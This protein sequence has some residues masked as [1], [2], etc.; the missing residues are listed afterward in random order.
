MNMEELTPHI[1]ELKRVLGDKANEAMIIEELDTYLNK[2]H[3]DIESAKRGIIRK[4]GGVTVGFVTAAAVQKKI[5]DL[6]GTEQ[7]VDIVAKVI[8]VENKEITVKGNPK[9]IVSG[10]IGDDT[11]SSSFTIWR[12]DV[13]LTK[14]DV[15]RF[16]NCYTKKWNDRI[17]VNLGDKGVVEL[18]RDVK[19]DMPERNYTMSSSEMKIGEIREGVGNVTVTGRIM[20]AETKTVNVKG[21]PKTV[22]AGIIADDTGKIQY[23]AWN[24]FQLKAGETICVKNA[25]IRA[26]KGIPQL[27]LG[28]RCEVSRVD[29]TFDDSAIGGSKE[30]TVRDILKNGGGLDIVLKGDVVDIRM[31]SGL[32]KRCPECNRSI[33]NDQCVS[34]GTVNPVPDLR[35]KFILDDGTGSIS[36]VL[37]RELT[38]K[39]TGVT[40]SAATELGKARGAEFVAKDLAEKILVKHVMITGNVMSDDY[41]PM[42]VVRDAALEKVDVESEARA[43]YK[44]VEAAL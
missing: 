17:Q 28:E 13:Q 21:E 11:G 43:L 41:G 31:G 20:T 2:Y 44:T 35:L 7:N 34:H 16:K 10:I 27:N 33:L 32:I 23:S 42:M 40:L 38:K 12:G 22:F 19:I 30:R 8:Y 25:Y 15:Y 14:G 3:L 1:E 4:L 36:A 5:G 9:S 29:D 24:D 6:N 37:N 39:L 26:W 18:A